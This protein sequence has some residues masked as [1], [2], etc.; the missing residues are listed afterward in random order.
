MHGLAMMAAQLAEKRVG[1]GPFQGQRENFGSYMEPRRNLRRYARDWMQ[2]SREYYRIID[3]IA[4]GE[5]P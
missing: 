3:R 1:Y 4:R 2:F 5:R